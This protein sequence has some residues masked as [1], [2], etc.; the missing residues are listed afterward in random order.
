MSY[1]IKEKVLAKLSELKTNVV[2]IQRNQQKLMK[3][4]EQVENDFSCY[5]Y[6]VDKA[7]YRVP[8]AHF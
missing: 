4:L 8:I 3:K 7:P 5:I 1:Q 2:Q 6:D